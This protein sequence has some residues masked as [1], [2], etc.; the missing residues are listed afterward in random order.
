MM[1]T[2][3]VVGLSIALSPLPTRGDVVVFRGGGQVQGKVIPDPASKEGEERVFVVLP[4]GKTPLSLRRDQIREIIPKAG[5]LDE[6]AARREKLAPTAAAE[7]ELGEWCE[8]NDLPDLAEVHFEAALKRDPD[9]AAARAKLG[10]SE[11]DGR[12]LTPDEMRHEGEG[13]EAEGED[14]GAREPGGSASWTRRIK[15]ILRGLASESIDRRR[16]AEAQLMDLKEPE[17][18]GPLVK[19]MGS[20]EPD[21]RMLLAQTLDGIP[22]D[23]ASRALVE[24]IL[25]EPEDAVREAVLEPLRRREGDVVASR[26]VRA[27]RSRDVRVINRAAW[28]L[29]HLEVF[30]AVPRLLDV[31]VT[32]EERMVMVP[33][34]GPAYGGGN[35]GGLNYGRPPGALMA[36]NGIAAAY[37][38]GPVVGPGVAAFGATVV[39][40]TVGF[41]PSG[42]PITIGPD[43]FAGSG[44]VGADRGPQ[45]AL[46]TFTSRNV[47]VLGALNRLTGQDFG[48]D[49]ATWRAWVARS[50]NPRP[51]PERKAPQP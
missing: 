39:P 11:R 24:M 30:A 7:Q 47:E 34:G 10:H 17:A 50:F 13:D 36:Y 37:L 42:G 1:R 46:M 45:P 28:A 9:F 14:E 25:R 6:Y 3:L 51:N 26:L 15:I 19:V 27:L 31:L 41:T 18:V 38:T 23:A 32:S 16:E 44:F 4:R 29:G 22:G 40:N 33:S 43:G 8:A 35:Y 49:Q 12:W 5:P 48:Y 20:G 21:L 2:A